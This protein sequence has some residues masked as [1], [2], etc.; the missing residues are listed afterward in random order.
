MGKVL[1]GDNPEG[2]QSERAGLLG[3]LTQRLQEGV[4]ATLDALS[5]GHAQ[6]LAAIVESSD[7]AIISKDLGG[8][9]ATWNGGAEKLFGYEAEEAIGKP[10]TMLAAMPGSAC[11]SWPSR[12]L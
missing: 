11:A 6:R 5:Q 8:I 7:D 1:D 9:I 12:T 2:G 3:G 10:I 4:R